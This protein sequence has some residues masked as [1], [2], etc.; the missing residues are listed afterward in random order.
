VTS[1][2]GI[3]SV[4]EGSHENDPSASQGL[5]FVDDSHAW[6]REHQG[7]IK[8]SMTTVNRKDCYGYVVSEYVY[9]ITVSIFTWFQSISMCP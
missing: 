6:P 7:C 2:V 3:I 5:G 4:Q 1:V 9:T 8:T